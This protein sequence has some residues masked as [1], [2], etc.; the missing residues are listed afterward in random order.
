MGK[1]F[2]LRFAPLKMTVWGICAQDDNALLVCKRFAQDDTGNIVTPEKPP[3]S[4]TVGHPSLREERAG[5]PLH[6]VSPQKGT[7]IL[8]KRGE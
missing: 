7:R 3:T 5:F 4:R 2:R 6:K 8:P 1:I